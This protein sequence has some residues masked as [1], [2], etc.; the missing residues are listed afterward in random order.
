M[1]PL[2]GTWEWKQEVGGTRLTFRDDKTYEAVYSGITNMT[3]N[4]TYQ[5]NGDHVL[6]NPVSRTSLDP[7]T[8]ASFKKQTMA[9]SD[10]RFEFTSPTTFN[11]WFEDAKE[12]YKKVD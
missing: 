10:T 5:V 6:F 2:T 12:E 11:L 9:S 3:I 8:I 7:R 4:G 1:Y